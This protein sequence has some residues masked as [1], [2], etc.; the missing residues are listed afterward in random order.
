MANGNLTTWCYPLVE[1]TRIGVLYIQ[2][3]AWKSRTCVLHVDLSL[4]DSQSHT[5]LN[6]LQPLTAPG[7]Y[8]DICFRGEQGRRKQFGSGGAHGERGSAS[9]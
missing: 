8:P 4:I 3:G 6:C 2:G 5:I 9:L 1:V 7:L